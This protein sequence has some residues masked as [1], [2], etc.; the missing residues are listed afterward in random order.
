M[1]VVTMWKPE[2]LPLPNSKEELNVNQVGNLDFYFYQAVMRGY[3][4][5]P[6]SLMFS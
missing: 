4:P 1:S 6:H 5:L 2:L 3:L